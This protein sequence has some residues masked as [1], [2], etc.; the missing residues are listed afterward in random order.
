[1]T[2]LAIISDLHGNLP[3][4]EAALTDI[5]RRGI[6][7]IYCLGDLVGKGPSPAEVVDLCRERCQVVLKGNW[8]DILVRSDKDD[9]V[10]R[11]H[12]VRLG[13]E[14]MAYLDRLPNV[15]NFLLS[16]NR[17]RLFH[18]SNVSIYHRVYPFSGQPALEAMFTNTEFTGF[19]HPTPDIVGYGDI[20]GAY[21]LPIYHRQK[22][23][24][25][26]GSVGNPLDENRAA[27]VIL[28]GE[29]GSADPGDVSINIVRLKYDVD[30]AVEQAR[31]AGMPELAPY[32]IELRTAVYR[33][34][35]T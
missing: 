23:I 4:L 26:V 34:R 28:E 2:Q 11:W 14:R 7:T 9:D 19:D 27:Y 8:D 13:P 17:V 12:R 33:D 32:E 31:L 21:L 10:L 5:D 15:L 29:L 30:L 25:N 3:A 16:G 1:M 6:Q 20:H 35:Q 24:F 22:T 18:A